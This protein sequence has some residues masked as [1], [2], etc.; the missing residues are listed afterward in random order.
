MLP[1]PVLS[2]TAACRPCSDVADAP[3]PPL[4]QLNC[5][6]E[7]MASFAVAA[8]SML[9]LLLLLQCPLLLPLLLLLVLPPLP[10]P[11]Q[12]PPPLLMLM[13]LM[14]L[15]RPTALTSLRPPTIPH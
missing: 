13:L 10:P 8:A 1:P 2:S 9:V 12:L 14:L 5:L 6:A 4:C 7:V 15:P 3:L 11:P